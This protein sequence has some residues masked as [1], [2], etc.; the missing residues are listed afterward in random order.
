M[1]GASLAGNHDRAMRLSR[2]GH[3]LV[4][5]RLFQFP[6]F[7]SLPELVTLAFTWGLP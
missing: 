4:N 7:T 6:A 1:T 2:L 5:L 3:R